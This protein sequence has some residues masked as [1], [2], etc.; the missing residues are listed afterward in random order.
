MT[1]TRRSERTTRRR[2]ERSEWRKLAAE[3]TERMK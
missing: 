1:T 3:R 2:S